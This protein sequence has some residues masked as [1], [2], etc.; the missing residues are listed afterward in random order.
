MQFDGREEYM[1]HE[2]IDYLKNCGVQYE[3]TAAHLPAQNGVAEDLNRTLIEHARAIMLKHNI[4]YFLW[5][6]A[7]YHKWLLTSL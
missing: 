4:P 2:V 3:I 6:E 5:P 1:N 7:I